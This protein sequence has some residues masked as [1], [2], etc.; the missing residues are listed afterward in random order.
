MA[1]TVVVTA[2]PDHQMASKPSLYPPAQ[3]PNHLLPDPYQPPS[4]DPSSSSSSSSSS[5]Q[6]SS[7]AHQGYSG[8]ER[9][10]RGGGGGGGESSFYA[11]PSSS[12]HP[13]VPSSRSPSPSAL[14]PQLTFE[15]HEPQHYHG[16]TSFG[17]DFLPAVQPQIFPSSA[18]H[19]FTFASTS[20][21]TTTNTTSTEPQPSNHPYHP[22]A[23]ASSSSSAVQQYTLSHS[24]SHQLGS[25]S[26]MSGEESDERKRRGRMSAQ[27]EE[28]GFRRGEMLAERRNV[29]EQERGF[30]RSDGWEGRKEDR[31][32]GMEEVDWNGSGGDEDEDEEEAREGTSGLGRRDSGTGSR[33][34]IKTR[35]RTSRAQFQTLE[36]M[37]Q[38]TSKPT[39]TDRKN[40]GE[41]LDM[42]PRAV[43]VW[44][45]NR[46]AKAKKQRQKAAFD[47]AEPL[48]PPPPPQAF[49]DNNLYSGAP[50]PPPSNS[51]VHH[52]SIGYDSM[53]PRR[54]SAG[55][56]PSGRSHSDEDRMGSSSSHSISP[57]PI[58]PPFV[59]HHNNGA[60]LGG[61]E[62][63]RHGS[64]SNLNGNGNGQMP[65]PPFPPHQPQ[66]QTNGQQQQQQQHPSSQLLGRPHDPTGRRSSASPVYDDRSPQSSWNPG[67]FDSRGPGFV[68]QSPR[69]GSGILGAGGEPRMGRRPSTTPADGGGGGGPDRTIK[70]RDSNGALVLDTGGRRGSIPQNTHPHQQHHSSSP[71]RQTIRPIVTSNGS[72]MEVP[73][74]HS[75]RGGGGGQ[76]SRHPGSTVAQY[77]SS[78]AGSRRSSLP[79]MGPLPP[80]GGS[81]RSPGGMYAPAISHGGGTRRELSP[82]QDDGG[83]ASSQSFGSMGPGGVEQGMFHPSYGNPGSYGGSPGGGGGPGLVDQEPPRRQQP[84]P[85]YGHGPIPEPS[86]EPQPPPLN[87]DRTRN[88]SYHH[89][90]QQHQP[91]DEIDPLTIQPPPPP[92]LPLPQSAHYSFPGAPL[93]SISPQSNLLSRRN[94]GQT[95]PQQPLFTSS[96]HESYAFPPAP[97]GTLPEQ[98]FSFGS[99]QQ[100]SDAGGT[101]EREEMAMA[102]DGSTGGDSDGSWASFGGGGGGGGGFGAGQ[103]GTGH[104]PVGENGG[105]LMPPGFHPDARRS[106]APADLL[107]N[108][109]SLQVL[110]AAGGLPPSAFPRPSPLNPAFAGLPNNA[111]GGGG[112]SPSRNG[113]QPLYAIHESN[114]SGSG[115]GRRGSGQG[116]QQMGMPEGF[117]QQQQQQQHGGQQHVDWA[118]SSQQGMDPNYPYPPSSHHQSYSS[119]S[120]GTNTTASQS[121][122]STGNQPP[123][124]ASGSS[125]SSQQDPFQSFDPSTSSSS[126]SSQQQQHLSNPNLVFELEGPGYDDE[127]A[128]KLGGQAG[129]GFGFAYR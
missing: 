67:G 122:P 28:E 70:R 84:H 56:G 114:H 77:L 71:S 88:N 16:Q 48:P 125:A 43:Q 39:Q 95:I 42:S 21:T 15:N 11:P 53:P 30:T 118:S 20:S 13:P 101:T 1:A 29:M 120:G 23:A 63:V 94:S 79:S 34:E 58:S 82:I 115:S 75:F 121:R 116:N 45:Q 52:P 61:W 112:T 103:D 62:T 50:P 47:G 102:R 36:T 83:Y 107:Q 72:S 123:H 44:F 109:S 97:I 119:S 8:T 81:T 87:Q 49:A 127:A 80:Q 76:G 35:R 54:A 113:V 3:C 92:P 60:P 117:V 17:Y 6:P 124:L 57:E 91:Y 99:Y 90:H 9:G 78:S 27:Q 5:Y 126:L 46:R 51:R 89:L 12:S 104:Y 106:S 110:G 22:A 128:A 38:K 32:G 24:S 40:L 25:S 14:S 59:P 98:G 86:Y 93:T 4:F 66:P 73:I 7:S 10:G 105:G 64:S 74:S 26:R 37:F 41:Q 100:G 108:F 18:H 129:G 19:P 33:G 68:L 85:F 111:G 69:R 31:R 2:L 55:A 96:P 65:P